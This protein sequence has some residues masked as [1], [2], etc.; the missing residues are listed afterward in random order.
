MAIVNNFNFTNHFV[1]LTTYGE[2]SVYPGSK[3][4][5]RRFLL[6][7]YQRLHS[8]ARNIKYCLNQLLKITLN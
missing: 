3:S 2:T 5:F 4:N 1:T 7:I 8:I 6:S